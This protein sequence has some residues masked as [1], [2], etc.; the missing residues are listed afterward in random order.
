MQKRLELPEK[1]E[2]QVSHRIAVFLITMALLYA[3][4]VGFSKLVN[5]LDRHYQYGIYGGGYGASTYNDWNL[6]HEMWTTVLAIATLVI[7]IFITYF[8]A[9]LLPYS[10]EW[11]KW[12]EQCQLICNRETEQLQS[13]NFE[14]MRVNNVSHQETHYGST[15]VPTVVS[16]GQVGIT[17]IP[18]SETEEYDDIKIRFLLNGQDI[19]E[20][21]MPND[22]DYLDWKLSTNGNTVRF[23][24]AG[25]YVDDGTIYWGRTCELRTAREMAL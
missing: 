10:W 15:V 16:G 4:W 2:R 19:I 8:I 18:T 7:V 22:P 24:H 21:A 11:R 5:L 1:P 9:K 25:Y 17:I 6:V 3:G 14:L 23:P 20:L 13:T 12:R